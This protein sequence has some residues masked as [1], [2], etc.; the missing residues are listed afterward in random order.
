LRRMFADMAAR[1]GWSS[2]M[3]SQIT[4]GSNA[5]APLSAKKINLDV[6]IRDVSSAQS[7][8]HIIP[9]PELQ[10]SSRKSMLS[11]RNMTS[12]D[13][14]E[15]HLSPG[16]PVTQPSCAVKSKPTHTLDMHS[17]AD[18][19]VIDL[20]STPGS[21]TADNARM[22]EVQTIAA[23]SPVSS[24]ARATISPL[25]PMQSLG[26]SP[27]AYGALDESSYTCTSVASEQTAL[28]ETPKAT[29]IIYGGGR[30]S[31]STACTEK[32][33]PRARRGGAVVD[34]DDEDDDL[35][36]MASI[37]KPTN[38]QRS[39]AFTGGMSATTS[40]VVRNAPI[41][42]DNS[43]TDS[44]C[45]VPLSKLRR[46]G[47]KRGGEVSTSAR[48]NLANLA[49]K[50]TQR[51]S[52]GLHNRFID[53]EASCSSEEEED[54]EEEEGGVDVDPHGYELNDGFV[55][56]DDASEEEE[57]EEEEDVSGDDGQGKSTLTHAVSCC[58]YDNTPFPFV[59][60]DGELVADEEEGDEDE[61]DEEEEEEDVVVAAPRTARK[62]VA[63]TGKGRSGL[64]DGDVDPSTGLIV[65]SE[66]NTHSPTKFKNKTHRDII[67]NGTTNF[68]LACISVLQH[69][70]V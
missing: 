30:S 31:C 19:T 33:V 28:H 49:G 65:I 14:N 6:A 62:A 27:G 35:P 69:D 13:D 54:N 1:Y 24:S 59:S 46:G 47:E 37:R 21:T 2:K 64:K 52:I 50:K 57:E 25:L 16:T 15:A 66:E 44:D 26:T 34:D 58:K 38:I 7:P 11:G 8:E 61:V 23:A 68:S 51:K 43:D 56:P 12:E 3:L 10:T 63:T 40:P 60:D 45:D 55:V 29:P 39:Q 53:D 18:N 32:T 42:Y 5:S 41:S 22:H 70:D 67:T 9:G 17:I 48:V 4:T 20:T 36:I